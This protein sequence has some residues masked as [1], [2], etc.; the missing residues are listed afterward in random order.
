MLDECILHFLWI[1]VDPAGDYKIRSS[2]RKKKKSIF[3]DVPDVT[4]RTPSQV[5]E[6]RRSFNGVLVVF[7]LI[8]V[9]EVNQA[10]LPRGK[11]AAVLTDDMNLAEHGST[12]RSRASCPGG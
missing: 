10:I 8:P 3:I 2:V 5:I 4:E 11:F 6:R 1:Y 7:E 9:A 12:D